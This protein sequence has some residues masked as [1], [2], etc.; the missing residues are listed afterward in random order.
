MSSICMRSITYLPQIETVSESENYALKAICKYKKEMSWKRGEPDH[1][2]RKT[3]GASL[4]CSLLSSKMSIRA[5]SS[6]SVWPLPPSNATAG[7]ETR[8]RGSK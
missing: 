4:Y 7:H 6:F 5:I 3:K 8:K 1:L 2:E